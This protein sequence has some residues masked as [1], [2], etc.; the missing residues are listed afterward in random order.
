MKTVFTL[1]MLSFVIVLSGQTKPEHKKKFYKRSDG[2]LFVNKDIPLYLH[3]SDSR[4]N[5]G[6]HYVL[7]SE[8]SPKYSAPFFLD[9]EG[10]NTIRTPSKVDPE[11]RKI[12][13]P[14]SDV[15]FEMFADGV[16]PVS[17]INYKSAPLVETGGKLYFGKGLEISLT[18]KDKMSGVEQVL[19]SIDG[20][21]YKKY[22]EPLK[23][24]EERDY[25][26]NAY[27]VD[28]VGNVEQ[29][30]LLKFIPDYTAPKTN[31]EIKNDFTEKIFSARTTIVLHSEDNLSGIKA[32]FYKYDEGSKKIFG[33]LVSPGW[34]SEG[35]H[36][37]F[38]FA[39]DKVN[40]KE[41]EKS[42][43]FFMDKTPPEIKY[44]IVGNKHSNAT[45]TFISARSK[46]KLEATDNKAGVKEL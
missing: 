8:S 6:E 36:T 24:P 27:A 46:I 17:I 13:L 40:N 31:V 10:Y 21:P 29:G 11:T 26:L 12:V 32:I 1:L 15:I 9:T 33:N 30:K 16:A 41:V 44:E 35:E 23:F 14:K 25:L 45:S 39:K 19:Y 42:F 7:E 20:K 22:A 28:N 18:S 34:I 37:F 5:T 4:E 3:I 38:Y 2:R 43:T